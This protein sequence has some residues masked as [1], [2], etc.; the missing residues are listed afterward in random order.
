V[1]KMKISFRAE[2]EVKL[3]GIAE[4]EAEVGCERHHRDVAD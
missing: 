1:E 2:A 4:A 3:R